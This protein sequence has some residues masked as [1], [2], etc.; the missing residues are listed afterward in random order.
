M[1]FKLPLPCT[2]FERTCARNAST[3]S[4]CHALGK[5]GGETN[6]HNGGARSTQKAKARKQNT[7]HLSLPDPECQLLCGHQRES[8]AV[9]AICLARATA[10]ELARPIHYIAEASH[11]SRIQEASHGRC[12]F[13]ELGIALPRQRVVVPGAPPLRAGWQWGGAGGLGG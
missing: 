5:L 1:R 3:A 9:V 6:N 2:M 4:C 13:L 12:G 11:A 8:A 10:D 7:Q